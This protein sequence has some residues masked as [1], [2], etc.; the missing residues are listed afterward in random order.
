LW[1][2]ILAACTPRSAG[3]I[4]PEGSP[5]QEEKISCPISGAF[6]QQTFCNQQKLLKFAAKKRRQMGQ[7]RREM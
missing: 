3:K 5:P 2:S 7:K 4:P 1:A 6:W